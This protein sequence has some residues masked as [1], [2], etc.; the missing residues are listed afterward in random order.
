MEEA[1]AELQSQNTITRASLEADNGGPQK[2][3]AKTVSKK[4]QAVLA[5]IFGTQ[6]AS[7]LVKGVGLKSL[8]APAALPERKLQMPTKTTVTEKFKYAGKDIE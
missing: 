1:W 3:K 7:G 2:K 5:G 8:M 4:A 6:T